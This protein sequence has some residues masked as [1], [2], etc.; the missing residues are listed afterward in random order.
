M[1][2]VRRATALALVLAAV[3]A[4]TA[5]GAKTFRTAAIIT[6]QYGQALL[7]AQAV[8]RDAYRSGASGWEQAD[9]YTIQATFEKLAIVGLGVTDAL[10]AGDKASAIVQVDAALA[11]L[12][13]FVANDI[14]KLSESKRTAVLIAVNAVRSVLLAYASALGGP[15]P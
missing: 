11:M 2:T 1:R 5:C 8:V 12:D 13:A 14:P 7:T 10:E 6:N 4:V 15:L 9:Y 3:M